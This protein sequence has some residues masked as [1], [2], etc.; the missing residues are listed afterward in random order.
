MHS[1]FVE[2]RLGGPPQAKF[3]AFYTLKY[4]ISRKENSTDLTHFPIENH[5]FRVPILK[6][7]ACGAPDLGSWAL[8]AQEPK[9]QHF[10]ARNPRSGGPPPVHRNR[11]WSVDLRFLAPYD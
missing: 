9:N 10:S 6:I 5:V 8:R 4:L 2:Q 1:V 7:F 11:L 3:L